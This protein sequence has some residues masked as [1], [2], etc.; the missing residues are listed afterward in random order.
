MKPGARDKQVNAGR[1]VTVACFRRR[2]TLVSLYLGNGTL[3]E[4]IVDSICGNPEFESGN[5]KVDVLIDFTRGSRGV[6][7][8]R[9]LLRSLL[10]RNERCC[11]VSLYHTPVL[12]GIT[13][14]IIP[15]RWNELIGLQHMKVYIF[16]DTLVIS[17][18]NLSNDYFT[19]RQDRYY[20]IRD[21]KLTDFY[22]GLVKKVQNFSL[23]LDRQDN[24]RLHHGWNHLPYK[25]S[26][27][28]FVDEARS[29]IRNFILD[30]KDE[31]NIEK[32]D[33]Y[34]KNK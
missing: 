27:F 31:Q 7:N 19:N 13:K 18:A 10:E 15:D 16:D 20:V 26:K 21:R 24:I 33:G 29:L 34:G 5:L 8:S 23:Q 2:I 30:V 9:K 22:C 1:Q 14:R 25:G 12:R 28:G 11:E 6:N 32:K 17:G 3:E 4:K